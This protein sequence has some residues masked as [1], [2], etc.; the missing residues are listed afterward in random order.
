MSAAQWPGGGPV[1]PVAPAGSLSTAHAGSGTRPLAVHQVIPSLHA[2][3]ASG[4]HT[5]CAREVLRHAGL[6]SDVFAT[7]ADADLAGEH[8]PIDQLDA[9]LGA[10]PSLILYQLSVGATV[11]DRLL[12]RPEPL[13]VNYHNLTP[14]SFFWQ[15]APTWL[16]A[17]AL[18]RRQLHQLAGRTCHAIADSAFNERDLVAAGYRST[19]VVPPLVPAG[20]PPELSR[21]RLARP[22]AARWL[23]VGKL[24]PHKQ[25]HRLVAALAAYRQ[26]YDAEASLTVVGGA[27]IPAYA[28]AVVSYATDLGVADAVTLAGTVPDAERDRCYGEADVFVCLSGHEG[29]CFPVVEA[30]ARGLP[31]VALD[32]GAVADTA[33]SGAVVLDRPSPTLVAAA[34]RRV[35]TDDRLRATLVRRGQRRAADF[36]LARTG[37]Q[38]VSEV[39]RAARLAGLS[40]ALPTSASVSASAAGGTS[41]SAPAS[42]SVS[43]P[44]TP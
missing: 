26:V 13:V 2:A 30:M 23:F 22:R 36:A 39:C 7:Q 27:P 24:L 38:L 6:V 19:A 42:A 33:G 44:G 31:V 16:D 14:A 18:G 34:V 25:V 4:S 17:V 37:P 12:H 5:L 21:P 35:L 29:F 28:D 3:D 41:A 9:A 20:S 11:V 40:A 1:S 15:W 32:A 10:G 8:R 43:A